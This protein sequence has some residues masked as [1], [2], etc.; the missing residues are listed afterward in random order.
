MFKRVL[1]VAG[2]SSVVALSPWS[3]IHAQYNRSQQRT[4]DSNQQA[5][6]AHEKAEDFFL[7]R[8]LEMNAEEA[9]IANLI[10]TRAQNE[11][12]KNFGQMM[13]RYHRDRVESLGGLYHTDAKGSMTHNIPQTSDRQKPSGNTSTDLDKAHADLMNRLNGLS[14]AAFDREALN[15]LISEHQDEIQF[16][17]S[18]LRLFRGAES[19]QTTS[20]RTGQPNVK[21]EFAKLCQQLLPVAKDHLQQAQNI[22]RGL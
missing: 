22:Q 7:P 2:F 12:L 1:F 6:R 18:H 13:A 15:V 20:G 9:E 17:E 10:A 19:S 3:Q 4:P 11:R 16:L 8:V 5:A 14:G 21:A